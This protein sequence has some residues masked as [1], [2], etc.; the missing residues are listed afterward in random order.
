MLN[1]HAVVLIVQDKR[2]LQRQRVLRGEKVQ[3]HRHVDGSAVPSS[4]GHL[5]LRLRREFLACGSFQVV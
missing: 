5:R 2:R 3:V 4:H 1:D